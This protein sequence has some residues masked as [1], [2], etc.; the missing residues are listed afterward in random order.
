MASFPNIFIATHEEGMANFTIWFFQ[1]LPIGHGIISNYMS[2]ELA[3]RAWHSFQLNFIR[4]HQ[5][6]TVFFPIT[7]RRNSPIGYG[8]SYGSGCWDSAQWCE[9]ATRQGK[10]LVTL[11][12]CWAQ[13]FGLQTVVTWD[14]PSLR[15]DYRRLSTSESRCGEVARANSTDNRHP[16]Y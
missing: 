10:S 15:N 2:S 7:F 14:H 6:G 5:S 9:S 8:I 16:I 3:Y 11:Q 13:G 4:A 12:L 1:N